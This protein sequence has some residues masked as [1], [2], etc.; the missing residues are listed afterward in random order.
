MKIRTESQLADAIDQDL[1]WRKKELTQLKF[2]L[3]AAAGR[4]DRESTVLRGAVTL[5]YA[6]WEGF[7]KFAALAYLEYI[8]AQR[9]RFDELAP[10]LLALAARSKLNAAANANRIR[11][12]IEIVEFFRASLSQ[13]CS[14]PYKDGIT[15]RANLS[16]EVLREIVETLGLSFA[17]FETKCNLIDET[18]LRSRNTIA[19]GEYLII[20]VGRFEELAREVLE[21]MENFRAQ[22]QNAAALQQ[23]K[24]A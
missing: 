9:L 5:L 12:H 2:L 21:M 11:A 23:F 8:A 6:H 16:S 14:L 18:L 19:H 22:V 1:I 24:A 7:V 4:G 15:T 13:R 3:D 20:T 10:A 17:P